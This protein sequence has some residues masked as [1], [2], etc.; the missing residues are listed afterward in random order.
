MKPKLSQYNF[1]LP[2]ELLAKK[3]LLNRDDSKMMVLHRES[4]EI[5]HKK[6]KIKNVS[7]SQIQNCYTHTPQLHTRQHMILSLI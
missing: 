5:E 3:P 1:D 2:S 6:F 4:G 7:N